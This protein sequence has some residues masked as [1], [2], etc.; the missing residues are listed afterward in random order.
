MAHT[1]SKLNKNTIWFIKVDGFD[2]IIGNNILVYA[3]GR[4]YVY[5]WV[6][7]CPF[8]KY[9]FQLLKP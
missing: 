5:F 1:D 2:E 7:V 3:F 9:K 6:L 4:I 8:K